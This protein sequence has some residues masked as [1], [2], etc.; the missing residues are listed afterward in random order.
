MF[1]YDRFLHCRNGIISIIIESKRIYRNKVLI[2][3]TFEVRG[4]IVTRYLAVLNGESSETFWWGKTWV[5]IFFSNILSLF[6]DYLWLNVKHFDGNTLKLYRSL[7]NLLLKGNTTT[8]DGT[9][10]LLCMER[11][12]KWTRLMWYLQWTIIC[13][14]GCSST[15]FITRRWNTI[16]LS[17]SGTPWSGH[18]V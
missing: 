12:Y 9:F 5:H 4:L 17:G 7:F 18:S 1:L 16:R 13:P 10:I 6:T 2:K 14:Q 3:L 15:V 8:L 11:T